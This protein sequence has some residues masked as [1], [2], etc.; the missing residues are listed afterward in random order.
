MFIY[1][2]AETEHHRLDGTNL[3]PQQY[4][5]SLY[6]TS[7]AANQ[8]LDGTHQPP[9]QY[10][11]S[12]CQ[13]S[14][15]ANQ[16]LDGTNLSPQPYRN[17]LFLTTSPADAGSVNSK[18]MHHLT[19]QQPANE[20]EGYNKRRKISQSSLDRQVKKLKCCSKRSSRGDDYVE[21]DTD[22]ST[23]NPYGANLPG[24]RY[25]D[26]SPIISPRYFYT[27]RDV[28]AINYL[29]I[30]VPRLSLSAESSPRDRSRNRFHYETKAD[31]SRLHEGFGGHKSGSSQSNK[32][33]PHSCE[34]SR[35][36]FE[37][38][39]TSLGASRIRSEEKRSLQ[40]DFEFKSTRESH[41]QSSK[42]GKEETSSTVITVTVH[43]CLDVSVF[44]I[45]LTMFH[46]MHLNVLIITNSLSADGRFGL[47]Q[48]FVR[49]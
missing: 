46:A 43:Y 41:H 23:L 6:E 18:D 16:R 30:P 17:S 21:I 35:F 36:A 48:R 24:I 12:L 33:W 39:Y 3:P 27:S 10:R 1:Y 31:L 49:F 44:G 25:I 13:T 7:E 20:Y 9:Q 37:G 26:E 4:R 2:L 29:T 22:E 5:N 19:V 45:T 47:N 38:G 34:T 28:S 15:A 8:R 42:R 40:K 32:Y 14:E 11:N